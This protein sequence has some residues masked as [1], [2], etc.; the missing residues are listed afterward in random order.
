MKEYHVAFRVLGYET[1]QV[2][3]KNKAAAVAEARAISE[4]RTL[5]CQLEL[6]EIYE[7]TN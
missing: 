6:D 7:I 3:A 5:G 4:L 1:F 2:E